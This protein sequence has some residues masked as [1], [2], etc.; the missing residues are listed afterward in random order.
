MLRAPWLS[1]TELLQLASWHTFP[2][3]ARMLPLRT[4]DAQRCQ[5]SSPVLDVSRQAA[6]LVGCSS[7]G[8]QEGPC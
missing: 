3:T 6:W 5:F 2:I 7:M 1:L 4:R 8:I